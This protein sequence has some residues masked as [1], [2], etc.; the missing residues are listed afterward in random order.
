[1]P[2]VRILKRVAFA[3]AA[4]ALS[5][6]AAWA[7]EEKPFDMDAFKAAQ[8]AGKPILVDAY[9]SWCPV[10]RAQQAVL[11]GLKTNPKYD[12]LVVFK[13]DYDNQRDALD[14]FNVQKQSTLIGFKGEKETG[15]SVGD[16]NAASIEKLIGTT[17]N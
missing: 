10:C 15:R 17:L 14:T 8:N 13:V 2:P 11:G 7:F 12:S 1:M 6:G 3:V 4:L 9:A 5:A 16:T